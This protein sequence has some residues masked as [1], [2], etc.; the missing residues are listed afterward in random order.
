MEDIYC[1]VSMENTWQQ[2]NAHFVLN[3]CDSREIVKQAICHDHL[4]PHSK[5]P[6]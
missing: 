1:L 5:P 6:V 4:H 2:M 3:L